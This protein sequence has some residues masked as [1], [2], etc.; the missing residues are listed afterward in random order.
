MILLKICSRSLSWDFFPSSVTVTLGFLD[1]LDV[2]CQ[3]YFRFNFFLTY[4]S[5]SSIVFSMSKILLSMS[6][7]L[8]VVHVSRVPVCFHI[9]SISRYPWFPQIV[10]FSFP[11]FSF[12]FFFLLF[13]SSSLEQLNSFIYFLLL[14]FFLEWFYPHFL[15]HFFLSLL[16]LFYF[17]FF[18]SIGFFFLEEK[19]RFICFLPLSVFIFLDFFKGFV[20]SY[21]SIFFW[22][23][24]RDLSTFF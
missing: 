5:I 11:P 24:L 23:S 6:Y 22:I 10:W 20:S 13:P 4:V 3:E 14:F 2:L 16:F 1:Y 9:H 17:T 7:I 15:H 12:F 21:L 8:L 19:N 18:L